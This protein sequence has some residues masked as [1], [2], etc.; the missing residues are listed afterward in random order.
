M[1][2]RID[3]G[4]RYGSAT[5]NTHTFNQGRKKC[6]SEWSGRR[7]AIQPHSVRRAFIGL[8]AGGASCRDEAG[9]DSR[10]L[11]FAELEDGFLMEVL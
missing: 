6:G 11:I 8:D 4:I 3:Q 2:S 10:G 9:D 5:L 7:G 1:R